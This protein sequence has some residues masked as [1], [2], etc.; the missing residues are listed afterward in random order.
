MRRLIFAIGIVSSLV[1]SAPVFA[2][3]RDDVISG[4]SRCAALKDDRQWLD[5]YYG[6]AQPMR[7]WLGLPP[8][9]QSQ[10]KLLMSQPASQAPLPA[11][12]T[13]SV[14]RAGPPPAPKHSSFFD[15]FGGDDVV[16]NAPVR[17]YDVTQKGFSVTLVDGE[18]WAQTGEDALQ[19]PVSWRMPASSMRVTIKQAALHT[20]NLVLGDEQVH[21]K[22][23]RV[24]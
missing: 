21:Y 17:S 11:A 16:N 23:Y 3:A 15:F 13:R 6:A 10:L 9:P 22:V 24:Q 2:D 19:N 12:V 5:C 4:M 20:F 1:A 8:A 18:V 14:V 7:A